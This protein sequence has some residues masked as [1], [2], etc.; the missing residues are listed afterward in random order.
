[1]PL[2]PDFLDFELFDDFL[3]DEGFFL[4]EALLTE[5]L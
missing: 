3:E 5:S 2:F 1:L 4:L